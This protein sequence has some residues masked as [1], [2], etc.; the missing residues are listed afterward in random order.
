MPADK[1]RPGRPAEDP[2]KEAEQK[3]RQI[4]L[5]RIQAPDNGTGS[6][7]GGNDW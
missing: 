6:T 4:A 3:R 7:L 5:E 2:R 1:K